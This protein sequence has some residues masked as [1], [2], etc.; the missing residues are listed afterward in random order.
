[1]A[2]P[3]VRWGKPTLLRFVSNICYWMTIFEIRITMCTLSQDRKWTQFSPSH[4]PVY[5]ESNL[6]FSVSAHIEIKG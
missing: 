4:L 3:F 2:S 6:S 1:M 5:T